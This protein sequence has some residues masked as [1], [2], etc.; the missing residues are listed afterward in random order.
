MLF[1]DDRVVAVIDYDSARLQQRVIDLAN[2]ALQFS[3]TGGS[4]DP[5]QWPDYL[6]KTRLKRFLLAYDA[7]NV[8]SK[9]E[10]RAVPFLMCEAMIAEAV[11]PIAATGSFGRMDG[12]PFLQMIRRK[13]KWVRAH[14]QEIEDVLKD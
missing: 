7:I 13:V 1:R 9:A 3:I 4:D 10:V 6:D 5:S 8:I 12:F 14:L 2:G 11:L